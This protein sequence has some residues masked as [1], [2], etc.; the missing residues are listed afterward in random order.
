MG[1][2][3]LPREVKESIAKGKQKLGLGRVVCVPSGSYHSTKTEGLAL[4]R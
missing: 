2:K 4:L 1:L 3:F